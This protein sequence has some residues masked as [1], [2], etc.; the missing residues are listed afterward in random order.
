[1]TATSEEILHH[2]IREWMHE[3]GFEPESLDDLIYRDKFKEEFMSDKQRKEAQ[4]FVDRFRN[5]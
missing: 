1:M 4:A 2:E 3:Q 5:R